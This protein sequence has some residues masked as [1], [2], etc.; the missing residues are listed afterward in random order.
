MGQKR[1]RTY[2]DRNQQLL[3][4]G[5]S[6]NV[7]AGVIAQPCDVSTV[8][9]LERHFKMKLVA[10]AAVSLTLPKVSKETTESESTVI[11]IVP[12]DVMI[13][14][15][16]QNE[17]CVLVCKEPVVM[18][19]I[20][21]MF[22]ADCE[23][24]SGKRKKGAKYVK[25]GSILARITM[26]DGSLCDMVTPVGGQL[27]EI[28]ENL[29]KKPSLLFEQPCGT[30]YIA[31]IYPDTDL[32]HLGDAP[33][34]SAA[35]TAK[36]RHPNPNICYAFLKGKCSRVQCRFAHDD[37]NTN[38]YV[39]G[40]NSSSSSSSSPGA[41]DDTITTSNNNINTNSTNGTTAAMSVP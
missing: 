23:A 18:T 33:T 11:D 36:K 38:S 10:T 24:I 30:G 40:N 2:I 1:K 31:V 5:R 39:E 29:L 21:Y 3:E 20:E 41:N 27:L 22:A 26:A 32:P 35:E 15:V 9:S 28:N 34:V 19:S 12:K 16:L 4:E 25:K 13:A 17:V 14:M 8:G 6:S 7:V 37:M